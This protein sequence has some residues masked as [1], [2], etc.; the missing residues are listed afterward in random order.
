MDINLSDFA[1]V[2]LL[3]V[4][5]GLLSADNALVVAVMI[6]GLPRQDQVKALRYGLVGA[7]AFRTIATLLAV[8]LIR[9]AWVKLAGG[10]YLVYLTYQ[11]FFR[12]G[13]A[14]ERSKPRPARPW[15]GLPALWA[16]ILKVELVNIA[17]SVDSILVAVAMSPKTWVVLT[18]GL[19]GIVAMR[20]VISRLLAIV[21]RYPTIVDGAF[22][23]IALVGAKLLMEYAVAMHWI[24]FEIPKW[25]SLAV[26]AGTFGIA[27][28]L[29]RRKGPVEDDGGDDD[30]VALLGDEPSRR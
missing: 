27:Y 16:T 15:M 13:S 10:L 8:Y 11:H 24:E 23:I 7:F 9:I 21:R 3:I 1:T 22:V 29:A 5:E 25:L 30:A 14:E 20:V 19:I 12:S 17:F 2:G 18:G 26:I 28:L 4:L 6:L